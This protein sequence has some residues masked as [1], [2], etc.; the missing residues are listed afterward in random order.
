MNRIKTALRMFGIGTKILLDNKKLII[1]PLISAVAGILFF[2]F[3]FGIFRDTARYHKQPDASYSDK[4]E[5]LGTKNRSLT[6]TVLNDL[7]QKSSY[8]ETHQFGPKVLYSAGK[9]K[10]FALVL[11]AGLLQALIICVNAAFFSAIIDVYHGKAFSIRESFARTYDKK[12]KILEWVTVS[13][14]VG[15]ILYLLRSFLSKIPYLNKWYDTLLAKILLSLAGL[16]WMI[17]TFFVIPVMVTE[18]IGAKD[19]IKRSMELLKRAWGEQLTGLAVQKAFNAA[20]VA[21]FL[22]FTAAVLFGASSSHRY[23][24]GFITAVYF[25]VLLTICF[26]ICLWFFN[27]IMSMFKCALYVYASEGVVPEYFNK[28]DIETAWAVK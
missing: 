13:L 26:L 24:Y 8:G 15:G 12:R 27:I 4:Y 9:T 7:K 17:G 18:N 6:M 5:Y 28:E 21:T 25:Q 11:F 1:Y 16:T 22:I 20:I 3:V 14:F 2:I 19:S 23:I 10:F